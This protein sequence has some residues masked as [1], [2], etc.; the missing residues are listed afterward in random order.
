MPA[1]AT[2][3]A[4]VKAVIK[5]DVKE[6][7]EKL[8][9]KELEKAGFSA[10]LT[11]KMLAHLTISMQKKEK[12]LFLHEVLK[13]FTVKKKKFKKKDITE[14]DVLYATTKIKVCSIVRQLTEISVQYKNGQ[15]PDFNK[16]ARQQIKEQEKKHGKYKF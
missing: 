16:E 11:A 5:Y 2:K 13:A 15:L 3:K 1:Y 10:T 8:I 4:Y 9:Q 6:F 14:L 12:A 7:Y